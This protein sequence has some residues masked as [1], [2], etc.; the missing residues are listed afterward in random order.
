MFNRSNSHAPSAHN[1]WRGALLLCVFNGLVLWGWYR[2]RLSA[3]GA[4]VRETDAEVFWTVVAAAAFF[5]SMVITGLQAR[6]VKQNSEFSKGFVAIASMFFMIGATA[7]LAW[8]PI[9]TIS[10]RHAVE[11]AVRQT[12]YSAACAALTVL[13]MALCVSTFR[14]FGHSLPFAAIVPKQERKLSVVS[15]DH[16]ASGQ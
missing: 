10:H 8:G 2:V 5:M 1:S 4:G 13:S 16:M 12:N 15:D 14:F 3:Y 11:S 6:N 9:D 7:V